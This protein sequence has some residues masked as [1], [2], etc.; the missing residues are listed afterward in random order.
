VVLPK[1]EAT[2]VTLGASVGANWWIRP[3]LHRRL[4]LPGYSR[5]ES[6]NQSYLGL[7]TG[8]PKS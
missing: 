4:R 5:N 3:L 7:A 2:E 6:I 1:T 8:V